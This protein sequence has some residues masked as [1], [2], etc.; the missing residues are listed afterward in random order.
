MIRYFVATLVSTLR[1]ARTKR[2]Q[3]TMLMTGVKLS[4]DGLSI[5]YDQGEKQ[6]RG[7]RWK[8]RM[9]INCFWGL[10]LFSEVC[11]GKDQY[12]ILVFRRLRS[13]RK[14][15][16]VPSD[17]AGSWT[18]GGWRHDCRSHEQRYV[19]LV[20]SIPGTEYSRLEFTDNTS[21]S[22]MLGHDIRYGFANLICEILNSANLPKQRND[23]KT[24]YYIFS[25]V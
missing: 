23:L 20:V 6:R 13:V 18:V 24:H 19:K 8:R 3:V 17:L 7:R 4:G 5:L 16:E 14:T 12:Y 10:Q 15:F 1:V 22:S 21:A 11:P 9:H 25:S 2:N